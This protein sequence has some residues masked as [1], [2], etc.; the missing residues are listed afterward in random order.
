[1]ADSP[2]V[3]AADTS[4]MQSGGESFFDSATDALVKGSSA[5]AVSGL[6]SIYNTGVDVANYF[7]ADADRIDVHKVLSDVDQNWGDYYEQHKGAIDTAGFVATA[8]IPGGLAVKGLNL[9]RRGS[10][11][12]TF[13]RALNYSTEAQQINLEKALQTIASPEGSVFTKMNTN[14]LK[15]I[16]WG[17]ADQ[18]LQ[19]ATFEIAV[20]A[21]MKASPLLDGQSYKDISQDILKTSVFGGVFGGAIEAVMLNSIVNKGIKAVD[22]AQRKYDVLGTAEGI[23]LEKS[24]EAY[25]IMDSALKLPKEVFEDDKALD[26]VYRLNGRQN[27]VTLNTARL[28]DKAKDDTITQSY[29][30]LENKITNQLSNGDATAGKPVARQLIDIIKQGRQNGV[31][32]DAIRSRLGDYLFGLE[33]IE[34]IG[35]QA[36]DLTGKLH[37]FKK[38]A[39]T[40]EFPLTSAKELAADDARVFRILGDPN[41]IRIATLGKDTNTVKDAWEQGFDLAMRPDGKWS[42]NP[43]SSKLRESKESKSYQ[44]FLN[45][46]SG[47][48]SDVATLSV[49]DIA[50]TERPLQF[51]ADGKT[52]TSGDRQ[53]KFTIENGDT[54]AF[55]A[56]DATARH[57]W[58]SKLEKIDGE[59]HVD[60]ISVLDAMSSAKGKV[61]DGT[62]VNL[63]NGDVRNWRDLGNFDD[64]VFSNKLKI[65]Q[66]R[67][68]AGEKDIQHLAYELNTTPEW[69]Q[70]AISSKFNANLR[71]QADN[72]PD[73]TSG[74]QRQLSDY[75]N[76]ENVILNYRRTEALYVDDFGNTFGKDA[77]VPQISDDGTAYL[78]TAQ[79]Q[80]GFVTGQQAYHYRVKLAQDNLEMA[81]AAAMDSEQAAKFITYTPDE[82][83]AAAN[84]T[85]VGAG[86]LTFAN[87]NYGEILKLAAQDI[88]KNT[89]LLAKELTTK[90]LQR[91]Q[92]LMAQLKQDAKAVGELTAIVTRV[93]RSDAKFT[94]MGADH[95]FDGAY[96]V[97][98]ALIRPNDM[99]TL[100]AVKDALLTGTQGTQKAYHIESDLVAN[101]LREHMAVTG[102]INE[103]R[104]VL[105]NALGRTSN[106]Q[107]DT[108]YMPPIDTTKVPYFAFVR[109]IEGRIAGDSSVSMITARSPAELKA[110]AEQITEKDG[111]QVIFKSGSED[112][113][114][115]LG[116][117]NYGRTLNENSIDSSLRKG[118][119]LGDFLP[120]FGVETTLEDF[121]NFH[122]RQATQLVRDGVSTKYAQTIQELERLGKTFTAAATSKVGVMDKLLQRTLQN[123]YDDV[124]KG[125]LDISKRSEFTLLH[126]T[127]EV[128]DALGTRAYR[129]VEGALKMAAA[130]SIDWEEA[131]SV[132]TKYGLGAPFKTEDAFLLSKIPADR[133]IL[134]VA[135]QKANMILANGVLR[136]DF[137]NS[138]VNIISTPIMLGTE[139]AAIRNSVKNDPEAMGKLTELLTLQVPGIEAK[140]P[141]TTKLIANSIKN[142][143]GPE[144]DALI[145]RYRENGDVT[146]VSNMYHE[147]ANDLSL[148]PGMKAG[149]YGGKVDKWVDKAAVFTGNR[150]AEEFTRFVSADVM[151][152]I[153]E[154]LV[155]TGK[156]SLQEANAFI[157]VFVNR[158]QGNYIA[159]QR[160]ILFQGTLGSALGLFQTYQFNMMQQLFRHIGDRNTAA[161]MTMGA[162]QSTIYG[163]NGLPGFDAIN[164]HIIGNANINAGHRDA[165]TFATQAAGKTL[166]DWMMYGTASAFPIFGGNG[167]AL[168]SRGDV[169]PRHPTIIP[170]SPLDI[171]AVDG[172]TRFVKN[173]VDV[174]SKLSD[175][176][177][178][179]AALLEGLEHNSIN[180][181]LAGLAQAIQGYSTTSK[182]GLISSSLD[183]FSIANASRI[184]GAKPL[185]ESIQLNDLYRSN[186][187]KA[188]DKERLEQLGE[189][190]KTT[191]RRNAT[192]TDAQMT[193]FM[194][195]YAASGGRIDNFGAAMQ[196]W[197]KDANTSVLNQLS[198]KVR[199][200][201]GQRFVEVMGGTRVEDFRSAPPQD[202]SVVTPEE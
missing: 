48:T 12:G 165:Y 196:R 170:V 141:S 87:A 27:K 98:K 101:F 100:V 43:K 109:P 184:L 4:N 22:K 64:F 37:Y 166:G 128:L 30:D 59:V 123:P 91:L 138:L 189:A 19:T 20:A 108:L 160:P 51:M 120:S 149:E 34:P 180:R 136:L 33:S 175:G 63:G 172:A 46:K 99:D 85:E 28:Y 15:A 176:G 53:W 75:G 103:K 139:V 135:L 102:E 3:F 56:V 23:G 157:S 16:G 145:K 144:K 67:L 69:I 14:Y 191:L 193:E 185:D 17:T 35:A 154:P 124:V 42:F 173:L 199:S 181:P 6:S 163:A 66:E 197:S 89:N 187:Y 110:L 117:Y 179:G 13:A 32:D 119:R 90:S 115:A 171:P 121:L 86:L 156:M 18:V 78:G 159:S 107:A 1:M 178:T 82:L 168:Y 92:P 77:R 125:M 97:D 153:T 111:L 10:G 9:V 142:W 80:L 52:V 127:N 155:S 164:T 190:V 106:R 194:G 186:A 25:S 83:L 55:D 134:K 202:A 39:T 8:F 158:V 96:L 162:L 2:Y 113:H 76:R 54:P 73:L 93:R 131:N 70:D 58:A 150:F 105:A 151:R 130:K 11:A 81:F 118:N 133:N 195:R 74:W 40:K 201:Y 140:I 183:T 116:D 49:A 31:E 167:P 200:P 21:T 50:T 62:T 146:N 88:G 192:P 182:G 129:A 104:A 5:A 47:A 95:G 68:G 112:Y 177:N 143:W 65:L 114:K 198:D 44:T 26:F 148:V 84:R 188:R 29:L 122:Q 147:M 132:L 169:N 38:G 57:A 79:Q 36:P 60:D 137:A 61:A 174:G 24:D 45:V 71:K 152:Q 126:Q 94:I 161:V 41:A 72:A 7:G